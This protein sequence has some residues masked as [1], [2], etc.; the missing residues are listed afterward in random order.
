MGVKTDARDQGRDEA[1]VDLVLEEPECE[2][3]LDKVPPAAETRKGWVLMA[4][5]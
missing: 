2:Q 4:R 5:E 1:G 3:V